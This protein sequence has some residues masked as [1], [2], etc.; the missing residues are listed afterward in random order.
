MN[1]LTF[2]K[3]GL[4]R[5]VGDTEDEIKDQKYAQFKVSLQYAKNKPGGIAERPKF[6][7]N[8]ANI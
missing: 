5:T 3:F 7:F 6:E 2:S 4:L 8:R 1:R